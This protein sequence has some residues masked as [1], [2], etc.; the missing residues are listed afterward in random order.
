MKVKNVEMVLELVAQMRSAQKEY[1]ST[2]T[3]D[4]LNKAKRLELEVDKALGDVRNSINFGVFWV[5]NW[6]LLQ[7][8]GGYLKTTDIQLIKDEL[9]TFAQSIRLTKDLDVMKMSDD[10]IFHE[11]LNYSPRL[12]QKKEEI[13]NAN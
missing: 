13:I 8:V 6:K 3:K 2:R 9:R 12:A 1:F 5:P 11:F 10:A 4:A 7:N